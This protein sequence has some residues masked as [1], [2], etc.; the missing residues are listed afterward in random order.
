MNDIKQIYFVGIGGI[1]MAAL[2]R[3]Y[4]AKG[5]PVA[6]YDRTPSPLTA[7]LTREGAIITYDDAA[8]TIP[9][10]FRDPLTTLVVFTPAI[11]GDNTILTYFR[12]A[13]FTIKKRA[14]VLG[15]I[16]RNSLGI[17]F[18][19]THGKTT[20]SSMA[21]HILHPSPIGCNAFLGGILRNY[22]S[23][24]LLS[25]T[26]PF[27]IIEADEYDRSFHHLRPYIAV[28]TATDPDHLDIYH[29]EEAYLES[30]AHFTSLI[31]PDGA[32]IV[33]EG[34]KL[35]PRPQ[36]GVALYTYSRHTGDFHAENIRYGQ[37]TI[38]FDFVG[39]D[40]LRID[41]IELGV[42][43]DINIDNAIA[44]LAACSLTGEMDPRAAR[45]AIASFMGPERRFQFWLR[46][47]GRAVIDD[48]AHHPD[49]L[50]ASIK[51]VRALYP[52]R[53][54]TVAFQ[55][56]LY[57]RTRDFAPQFAEALSLA[58]SVILLDIYPAREEPIPGV[59]SKIIFDQISIPDKTMISKKNLIEIVKKLNFEVLLT[60]GA[61]DIN[62]ALPQIIA[63]C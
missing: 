2:A 52:G 35:R 14:E 61:G 44:A 10:A 59:T 22:N 39:P 45:S 57:S 27:T 9:E 4:L 15:L 11:P 25:P 62:L 21:A 50:K 55:P 43:V 6:G 53:R 56:H 5:L 26:S 40:S 32:L 18:A 8:D 17:C 31:R 41:D 46:E 63:E 20:T 47:P 24:L 1:G 29:T 28:I 51:S 60:V 34:L 49:E 13:D 38:R 16:T 7:A 19:G 23:N 3:Y 30:F 12:H 37:G 42:P 33:H 48:Y 36:T 54:L 58:D